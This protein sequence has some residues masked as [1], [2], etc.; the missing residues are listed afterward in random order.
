MVQRQRPLSPWFSAYAWRYTFF[1]PS[2]IH[3]ATGV[4]LAV[5]F[6]ALCYFL[7]SLAR[8]PQSYSQ[9]LVIFG[10]PI[11]KVFIVGCVWS[12]FFHFS[13]GIRHLFWDA[14]YGFEKRFARATG[15]IVIA[16]ATILTIVSCILLFEH[17]GV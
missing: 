7:V 15:R 2:V 9:A 14:G 8:G 13:N 16:A 17:N 1:N 6:L 11:F 10:N 4:A 3:R 5:G 12:F